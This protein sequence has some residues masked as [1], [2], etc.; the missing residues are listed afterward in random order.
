MLNIQS[1]VVS[2]FS[3]NSRIL[4]DNQEKK[5]VIIDPGAE[6]PR[7]ISFLIENGLKAQKVQHV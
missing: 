7:L 3:Q 6:I 1:F 2:P 4:Y 5:A